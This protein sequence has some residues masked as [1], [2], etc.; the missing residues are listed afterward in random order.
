MDTFRQATKTAD[1][2]KPLAGHVERTSQR[3]KRFRWSSTFIAM[4]ILALASVGFA[5]CGSTSAKTSSA[6]SK[7]NFSV[8]D[9]A[10]QN[11]PSKVP[12]GWVQITGT[13]KGSG[14]EAASLVKINKG[15]T[16]DQVN[17]LMNS[18][19]PQDYQKAMQATTMVGGIPGM[20]PNGT[21]EAMVNLTSGNYVLMS[22]IGGKPIVQQFTVTSS[23]SGLSEPSASATVKLSEFK[24]EMPASFKA[25]STTFKVEN[26][27]GEGHMALFLHLAPGK[28]LDD[29]VKFVESNGPPSGPPP[30]DWAGGVDALSPQHDGYT[31]IDLQPGKYAVICPMFDPSSGKSHAMLGMTKEITVQ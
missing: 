12:S 14:P 28:T 22:Q 5:A 8:T 3:T 26:I 21:A 31:T 4:L 10:F 15:Y 27:G 7:I 1:R 2:L 29:A 18:E 6:N 23:K 9:S 24:I 20:L 19:N 30:V 17:K 11:F 13:N 16:Y 25:G